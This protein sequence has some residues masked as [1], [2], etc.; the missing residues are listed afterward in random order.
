MGNP[1]GTYC[2]DMSESRHLIAAKRLAMI[3]NTEKNHGITGAAG[4]HD[5][6]QVCFV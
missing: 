1:T 3:N 5:T 4:R 2:L 6:S